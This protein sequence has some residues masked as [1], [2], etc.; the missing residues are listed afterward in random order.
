MQPDEVQMWRI[1]NTSGRSGA[2]FGGISPDLQW[3]Q[4]AQDGVQFHHDNYDKSTNR[5]SRWRRETASTC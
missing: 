1:A 4:L 2:Y 3:K 5:P